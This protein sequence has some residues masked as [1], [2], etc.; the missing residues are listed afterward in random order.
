MNVRIKLPFRPGTMADLI[1][2]LDGIPPERIRLHPPP[3]TA[4]LRDLEKP[5]NKLCE[6]LAG[7]L[8]EKPVGMDES[9]MAFQIGRLILNLIDDQDL[10]FVSGPDGMYQLF[11]GRARGPDV[12]FIPWER[13]PNGERPTDPV[14]QV[15]PT[16]VVEVLSQS[17]TKKEMARKRME[18]FDAGVL[19]VWEIDPKARSAKA[20]SGPNE[21]TTHGPSGK[22]SAGDVLPGFVLNLKDLFARLDKRR[23]K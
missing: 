11:P 15:V 3:G 20:Y 1:E 5:E 10:G 21:F 7:T 14:P 2:S 22:L 6:L 17:N 13:F 9:M 4:T 18:Y 16:F 19:L 8:V 12:A 23:K